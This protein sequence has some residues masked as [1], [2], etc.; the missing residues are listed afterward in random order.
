METVHETESML[1]SFVTKSSI[2]ICETKECDTIE[3]EPLLRVLQIWFENSK[4]YNRN[5]SIILDLSKANADL[6]APCLAVA[7]FFT[8]LDET[9][10]KF[11]TR[12][13]ISG[14][15][16]YYIELLNSIYTS[17]V[18][19]KSVDTAKDGIEW[20]ENAETGHPP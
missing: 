10:S 7:Q 12:V 6:T 15:S 18:P 2:L 16:W 4:K 8:N 14:C 17:D 19:F 9:Y 11:L 20:I 1:A 13:A 3:V 5:F